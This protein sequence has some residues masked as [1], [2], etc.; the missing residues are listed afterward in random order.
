VP[1]NS[2][3]K[4]LLLG[5]LYRRGRIP[6]KV[7]GAPP[8]AGAEASLVAVAEACDVERQEGGDYVEVAD[9]SSV[10]RD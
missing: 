5:L 1:K 7:A 4:R 6:Q 8:G 10:I 9:L 2:F 3:E